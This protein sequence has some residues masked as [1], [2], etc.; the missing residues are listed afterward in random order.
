[1]AAIN[2]HDDAVADDDNIMEALVY[3]A[4]ETYKVFWLSDMY[5]LGVC[6]LYAFSSLPQK[7]E[8]R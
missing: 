2:V 5:V 6:E 3:T 1:M 4:L 8:F 7:R